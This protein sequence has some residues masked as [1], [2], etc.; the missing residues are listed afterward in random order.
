MQSKREKR[1]NAGKYL[2]FYTGGVLIAALFL[3]L[4]F[5]IEGTS[6]IKTMDGLAQHV[7]VL[8]HFR[9]YLVELLHGKISFPMVDFSI[10]Q[11]F[12]VI[13]TLNYYGVGDPVN[14]LTVLFPA[15]RLE[16]MYAFLILFRMYLSGLAFSLYFYEA[17]DRSHSVLPP[18][19]GGRQEKKAAGSRSGQKAAGVCQAG[20][21]GFYGMVPVLCG[22]WLYA[23]CGFALVGGMKHPLFLSG[24]LYLPLLLTGIERLLHGRSIRFLVICVGLAFITNYYFMYMN[25]LLCGVYILVRLFGH[26]R[27]YGVKRIVGLFLKI[28]GAWI[29]GVCLSAV[30]FFPAAYAF[31]HNARGGEE[32]TLTAFYNIRQYKRAF[33]TLFMSIPVTNN[34]TVPGTAAAGF[35]GVLLVFSSGKGE[36]TDRQLR[37]GFLVLVLMLALPV[38][39]KVMNGFAYVTNRWSYGVAFACALMTAR[40][41]KTLERQNW[42]HFLVIAVAAVVA[43]ILARDT[44]GKKAICAALLV[45]LTGALFAE[46]VVLLKRGKKLL[47]NGVILGMVLFGICWN[48]FSLYSSMGGY[49]YTERFVKK[50]E[51]KQRLVGNPEKA[52]QYATSK[53]SEGFYRVA[54]P[55]SIINHSLAAGLNGT[56]FYY[57]VIPAS[58]RDFYTSLGMAQYIRPYVFYG[59]EGRQALLD[60][61]GTKYRVN[62]AGT[63]V[64]VNEDA[65]PLG[66]TYDTI[67][68][69][70]DYDRLT[71]LERQVA[72]ME[73]AV[74]DSEGEQSLLAQDGSFE[75]KT[76]ISA[77]IV[78][79]SP[80]RSMASG[81]VT[82]ENGQLKGREDGAL[83]ILF[84]NR[85]PSESYLILNHLSPGLVRHHGNF[86]Y[87]K[88]GK[89]NMPI[90]ISTTELETFMQRDVIA[91]NLGKQKDGLRR[92]SLNFRKKHSYNLESIEVQNLSTAQ[93]HRL[94]GERKKE[95]MTDVKVGTN[96]ITGTITVSKDR[97][98]QLA[99]PESSGWQVYVDGK[100]ADIFT[101]GIA[102]MGVKLEPGE[103]Q[104][105]MR[106]CS[107]GIV[108]G[109]VLSVL[110][111]LGLVGSALWDIKKKK[112]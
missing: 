38:A 49:H 15:D 10:G 70:A 100:K 3:V 110:A 2:L 72:L 97:I 18:E 104:I 6:F 17:A 80:I 27:E 107:P 13:G 19:V 95:S 99:V 5:Q 46:S 30:I 22:A 59:L 88:Q 36:K 94:A 92:C 20:R 61:T 73:C 93:I 79:T 82:Y 58:M 44:F 56:S 96:R 106:Y 35:T 50:G 112:A 91:V 8:V 54:L 16:E 4:I 42:K 14:L 76:G 105:E 12:D 39:G 51:T 23:F 109:L 47:A 7:A 40:A 77:G 74:V 63:K 69:R 102:Y 68:T 83:A 89:R 26:Y 24:M 37:L 34:W 11:G 87:A 86:L 71:P 78:D 41:I 90:G 64:Y 21:A 81:S 84:Q 48:I 101:S 53:D 9:A 60:L 75:T 31:L 43:G 85:E 32:T 1:T 29:W 108:A 98:L 111:G 55:S 66:Y 45:G 57:S 65:L 103:H 67:M 62:K 28:A 33:L 25:T 52:L